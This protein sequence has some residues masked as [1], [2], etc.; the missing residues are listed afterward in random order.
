M[1]VSEA[2]GVFLFM[3]NDKL[4]GYKLTR[5][6]FAY[7]FENPQ[8][9]NPTDHGLYF[10]VM[11]CANANG[12]KKSFSFGARSAMEVL[13]IAHYNT[14]KKSFD[15]LVEHG[16]IKVVRKS[17][18]HYQATIIS[19]AECDEVTTELTTRLTNVVSDKVDNTLTTKVSDTNI[20]HLTINNKPKTVSAKAPKTKVLEMPIDVDPELW[21]RYL[22]LN[23]WLKANAANILKMQDQLTVYEYQKL[24]SKMHGTELAKLFIRM[25]NWKDLAKKNVSVYLTATNWIAREQKETSNTK[26]IIRDHLGRDVS[27]M[28]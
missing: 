13:G 27:R 10:W 2:Q 21:E 7:A 22:K 11:E 15:K 14:Y 20:K 8:A 18:N 4:N 19:I 5:E 16:F 24:S 9:F 12:W 25:H 1:A 28:G 6:W 3:A 26:P 17:P 23:E